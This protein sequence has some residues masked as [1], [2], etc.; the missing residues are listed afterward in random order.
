MLQRM[1]SLFATMVMVAAITAA[2]TQIARADRTLTIFVGPLASLDSIWMA[3]E[4][5][6]FKAA[7][8]D[9]QM[10][11]FPSGTTALQTF[12]NGAGD[13]VMSGETPAVSYWQAAKDDYR[14]VGV[15]ERDSA[16]YIAT[17]ADSIKTPQDLKGRTIATRVGSTGSWFI[18]E[19]LA[20]N[21]IPQ[22]DVTV[23]N[24][25]TQVMP[26]ALCQGSVDGIF[27]W[28]PFGA[29]AEQICPGKLHTL[30][31]ADGYINGYSLFGARTA[32]LANPENAKTVQLF[33]AAMIKGGQYAK[34]HFADVAAYTHQ[35]LGMDEDLTKFTWQIIDRYPGFDTVF[36][37]DF[38]HLTSWMKGQGLFTGTLDFDQL[39]YDK[40]LVA[41]DPKWDSMPA[42]SCPNS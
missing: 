6:Y 7:G 40:A 8:L 15:V 37:N 10:K 18:S 11:L 35:K 3:Q 24:L 30:A 32:W 21:G 27:I 23:K 17:V 22:S 42:R 31:N 14:I 5:G 25:D 41:L 9:V 19:Y 2:S 36:Y 26:V 29:Q 1:Q 28:H 34:T 13:L 33:L 20:K 16:T 39:V 38:C 4:Q 12:R